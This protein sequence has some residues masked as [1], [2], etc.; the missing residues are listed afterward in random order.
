[1]SQ[2]FLDVYGCRLCEKEIATGNRIKK[3]YI[4]C[5]QPMRMIKENIA[6][7]QTDSAEWPVDKLVTSVDGNVGL[8]GKDYVAKT[9]LLTPAMEVKVLSFKANQETVYEK[10][11]NDISLF[12]IEG[13]GI[14]ALGYEDI[15]ISESS[16][17]VVPKG[18]LWGIKN[19][20]S[21]PLIVLQ[22]INRNKNFA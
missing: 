2:H 1:M 3:E 12:V 19:S 14:M 22:T 20:N 7:E 16:V 17:V 18:M 6:Y 4:C 9:I 15:E 11:E 21:S 10:S 5:D 13:S 8:T